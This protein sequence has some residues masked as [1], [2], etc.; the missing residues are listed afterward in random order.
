MN[1]SD[2]CNKTI[3]KNRVRTVKAALFDYLECLESC[4]NMKMSPDSGIPTCIGIQ[5]TQ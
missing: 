2:L 1:F 5:R 3:S 4:P